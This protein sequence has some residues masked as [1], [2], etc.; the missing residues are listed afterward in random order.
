MDQSSARLSKAFLVAGSAVLALSFA[1]LVVLVLTSERVRL[2]QQSVVRI[3]P[4]L[5]V[6]R[7]TEGTRT[8]IEFWREFL[9]PSVR[10]HSVDSIDLITDTNV[11]L[12]QWARRC[13]RVR[14]QIRDIPRVVGLDYGVSA[15]IVCIADSLSLSKLVSHFPSAT[16]LDWPSR[17]RAIA[18]SGVISIP[19]S[20]VESDADMAHEFVHLMAED[21]CWASV[22]SLNEGLACVVAS[23]VQGATS[24]SFF[25]FVGD[26]ARAMREADHASGLI[27][28]SI[29]EVLSISNEEYLH[30]RSNNHYHEASKLVSFMLLCRIRNLGGEAL[31]CSSDRACDESCQVQA[32]I[33][34]LHSADARE[35]WA[36]FC[37]TPT[38]ESVRDEKR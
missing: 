6:E 27:L 3:D 7:I 33:R 34:W 35:R 4:L 2:R 18:A 16:I 32:S 13:L 21:T 25:S 26:N 23:W 14:R 11:P 36:T 20:A 15:S 28:K 8:G 12:D 38:S 22:A 37:G 9:G 31:T 29:D 19:P 1:V 24:T 17:G 5:G 10:F 30:A